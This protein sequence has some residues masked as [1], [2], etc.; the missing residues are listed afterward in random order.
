MVCVTNVDIIY[1]YELKNEMQMILKSVKLPF[2]VLK[3]LKLLV[4]TV[5][6]LFEV[7]DDAELVVILA[8]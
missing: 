5:V 7:L 6:M 4:V 1:P 8:A 3:K 2:W